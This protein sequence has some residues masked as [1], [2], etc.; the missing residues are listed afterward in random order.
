MQLAAAVARTVGGQVHARLSRADADPPLAPVLAASPR[1]ARDAVRMLAHL[2][3]VLGALAPDAAAHTSL[4]FPVWLAD[5]A[6][7]AHTPDVRAAVLR[8]YAAIER[9][10]RSVAVVADADRI[11]ARLRRFLLLRADAWEKEAA[12]DPAHAPEARARAFRLRRAV[13]RVE[14]DHAAAWAAHQARRR[15][16]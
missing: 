16:Q 14:A 3:G 11:V 2:L 8:E 5:T 4:G 6:M 10:G 9:A 13:A 12:R 7:R 1:V 15:A